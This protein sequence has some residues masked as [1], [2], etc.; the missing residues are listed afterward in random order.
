MNRPGPTQGL[1][2]IA[3]FVTELAAAE[4]FFVDLISNFFCLLFFLSIFF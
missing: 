1:R 2:H 3:L 4:H